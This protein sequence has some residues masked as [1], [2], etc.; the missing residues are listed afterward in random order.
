MSKISYLLN[1]RVFVMTPL[2]DMMDVSF[3]G[4]G[5][6]G[7]ASQQT[8]EDIVKSLTAADKEL[9]QVRIYSIVPVAMA[10]DFDAGPDWETI[11]DLMDQS[12]GE[13]EAPTGNKSN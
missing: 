7:F 11:G 4:P 6:V 8:A 9:G 5:R 10:S 3:H 12:G 1:Y 2:G 13:P